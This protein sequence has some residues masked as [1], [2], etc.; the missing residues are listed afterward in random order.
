[1]LGGREVAGELCSDC[2]WNRTRVNRDTIIQS[3]L[4]IFDNSENQV[5]RES[6]VSRLVFEPT[7]ALPGMP[8]DMSVHIINKTSE[9][10]RKGEGT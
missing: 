1:M 9:D 6:D 7:R 10:W 2:Q 5:N 4:T 3:E 8:K